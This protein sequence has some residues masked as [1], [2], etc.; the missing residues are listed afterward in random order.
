[1]LWAFAASIP[2]KDRTRAVSTTTIVLIASALP[3]LDGR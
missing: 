2:D 1:M 3:F